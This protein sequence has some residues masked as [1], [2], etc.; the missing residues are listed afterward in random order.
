MRRGAA[1]GL[2]ALVAASVLRAQEVAR[3]DHT[4][5][6]RADSLRLLGRPWHAA[7]TLLA[8]AR[9]DPHPNAF[10]VVEGAKAEVHAKRYERVSYQECLQK[11]LNV[12]DMT[13][14]ALCRDNKLPICVFDL[15]RPGNIQRV[16]MGEQVGTMVAE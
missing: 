6:Y 13:A 12:M 15:T 11:N 16:V 14:F 3:P 2:A 7:E 5:T 4:A 10:L 1:F 8:A 9:R